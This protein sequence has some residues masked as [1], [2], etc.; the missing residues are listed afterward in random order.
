MRSAGSESYQEGLV[1]QEL[2]FQ[3][4]TSVCTLYFDGEF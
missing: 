4:G 2:S 1:T 3:I